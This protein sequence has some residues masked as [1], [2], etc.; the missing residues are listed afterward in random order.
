MP[1]PAVSAHGIHRI[2]PSVL[3]ACRNQPSVLTACRIPP[4]VLTACRNQLSVLTACRIQPSVLTACRIPQGHT[5][6]RTRARSAVGWTDQ[7]LFDLVLVAQYAT[8][9]PDL[10]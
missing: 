8:S 3:T 4:S 9:V 2:P 10:A 6:T 7:A 5:A 1:H